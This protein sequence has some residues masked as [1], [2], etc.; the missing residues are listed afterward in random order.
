MDAKNR[1]KILQCKKERGNLNDSYAVSIMK[2]DTIVGHIPL[3]NCVW[4][5][6]LLKV[7]VVTS[8]VTNQGKYGT[9][10]EIPCIYVVSLYVRMH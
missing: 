8:Q 7:R 6:I 4:C 5:G 2:D 10:L 1:I 3:K 9:D